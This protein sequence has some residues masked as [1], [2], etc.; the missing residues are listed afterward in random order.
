[1]PTQNQSIKGTLLAVTAAILWGV[2]GTCAQYL[3][4]HRGINPE[5]LVTMRLL[6]SGMLLLSFA[7]TKKN[8]NILAIFKERKDAIQLILFSILGMLA[9]QYTYFAAILHSN[10]ATATILQYLGPVIIACYLAFQK[11]KFPGL[12]ESFAILLA[13]AGTFFLVSHGSI[14][15]LSISGWA[16]F[17][18]ISSAV[19]LAYY[20]LQP[21]RLLHKWDAAIVIGW[22][23]FI[24]GI[25]LSFVHQPWD[26]EGT[27]DFNTYG[28]FAFIILFGSLFAFYA[29]LVSVKL[30][31]ATVASLLACTEPLSAAF[32]AVL[33]LNVRFGYYDWLGTLLILI[34]IVLLSINKKENS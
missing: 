1:M 16:L 22:G 11:R 32:L 30:V 34:T 29:Y 27:W 13:V 6:I 31:G 8:N 17:W 23:M 5:W 10:A 12:Q 24:G 9:V 33:W 25:A 2:S 15:S 20:S 19:A 4:Q 28:L 7:A 18:G 14:S 21:I 26:I 3:F